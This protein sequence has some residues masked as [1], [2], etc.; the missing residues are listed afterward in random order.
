[1]SAALA[2]LALHRVRFVTVAQQQPEISDGE[3]HRP[4]T[5]QLLKVDLLMSDE[6]G[7]GGPGPVV[8][9]VPGHG[10]AAE[11]RDAQPPA[12]RERGGAVVGHG[13]AFS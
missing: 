13:L 6:A 10:D 8:G 7:V 1:M 2:G 12:K 11:A 4:E 5:R 9:P 3:P